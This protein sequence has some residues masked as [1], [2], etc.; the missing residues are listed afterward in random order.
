MP[1]KT[2]EI[3]PIGQL[4]LRKSRL[5]RHLRISVS[6]HRGV[7]VSMPNWTPYAAGLA[8]ARSKTDWILKQQSKLQTTQPINHDMR[9]GKAHRV[10]LNASY[11]AVRVGRSEITGPPTASQ[12]Q[13][14]AAAERALRRQAMALLPGRLSQL[15][16]KTGFSY[17][18]LTI[19]KMHSRWGSC[20]SA[21]AITLN[22]FLMQ[23][24]WELIDYVITHEL[25]H[26]SHMNHS[27]E[28]WR[29]LEGLLPDTKTIKKTLKTYPTQVIPLSF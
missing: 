14:S 9:I 28:F 19:K 21:G 13:L 22:I 27:P 23:L 24:P 26:T 8:F 1:Q 20:N 16:Q 25:V 17:Q 10:N 29:T 3:E 2:V 12:S 4:T 11:P 6:P 7:I 15:A 18:S 5:S